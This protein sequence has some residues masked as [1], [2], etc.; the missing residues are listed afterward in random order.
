MRR[1]QDGE[2]EEEEE[3]A[4]TTFKFYMSA[5]DEDMRETK[6]TEGF[7][8]WS[9]GRRPFDPGETYKRNFTSGGGISFL[10]S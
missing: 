10:V 7:Q 1:G 8:V 6:R 5:S 3:A 4:N 2:E 9:D